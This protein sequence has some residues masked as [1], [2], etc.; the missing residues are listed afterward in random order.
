MPEQKDN[1]GI[2]AGARHSA[3]DVADMQTLHDISK[4]QGAVC[5]T[6]TKTHVAIKGVTDAPNLR[7]DSERRCSNCNYFKYLPPSDV[8]VYGEM[9]SAEGQT[10]PQG[11]CAKWDFV[12]MQN[13]VCDS[14]EQVKPDEMM[15][16]PAAKATSMDMEYTVYN[17]P[18]LAIKIAGEM[19]L[20]V[21]YMPYTG[22]KNGKD[23]D[24]QYFSERTNEYAD[25]FPTPLVLYYHGY[26]RQGVQQPIPEEIGTST[27]MKWK[28]KAGRWLRVKLDAT[29]E[30]AMRVW[31]SAQKGNARASSDSISHLVRVA[32]DGEIINWA[33]VGI[34]LFETETGKKP[35]NSYAFAIPAAKAMGITIP[36]DDED[37]SEDIK[38]V[39]AAIVSAVLQNK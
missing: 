12:T 30:K 14:W 10:T 5:E 26:E 7:G 9:G 18:P 32:S 33:F 20:D 16:M 27:G 29:K 4:R 11:I 25:K 2:K 24:G 36:E 13:Y 38:A 15:D 28:D 39:T 21:C 34:S 23:S 17:T 3:S 35:A 1:K 31:N 6:G 8:Y 22:Q 37:T 19:E